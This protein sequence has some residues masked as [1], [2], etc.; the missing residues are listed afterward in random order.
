MSPSFHLGSI[1]YYT[2]ENWS[3]WLSR[4]KITA[5]KER[6]NIR[7]IHLNDRQATFVWQTNN[8]QDISP[9]FSSILKPMSDNV[10]LHTPPPNAANQ[11]AND[12]NLALRRAAF[13]EGAFEWDFKSD[14]GR[15]Y[16]DSHN[17]ILRFTL[18]LNQTFSVSGMEIVEGNRGNTFIYIYPDG[19]RSIKTSQPSDADSSGEAEANGSDE[20]HERMINDLLG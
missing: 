8:L 6:D 17:Q 5:N 14:D 15:I 12:V 20:D 16:L 13:T 19:S 7:I 2:P 10:A 11:Q 9:N 3:V 1:L 18:G 4:S